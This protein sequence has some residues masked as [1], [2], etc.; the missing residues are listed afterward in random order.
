MLT[1]VRNANELQVGDKV[2]YKN[3]KGYQIN[4]KSGLKTVSINAEYDAK[5]IQVCKHH[6]VLSVLADN[7][8]CY[9]GYNWS[10]QRRDIG[11]GFEQ[12]FWETYA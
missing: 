2:R 7:P 10:I 3:V 9:K 12:L 6:I 8:F 11:S 5:V 4:G 1:M